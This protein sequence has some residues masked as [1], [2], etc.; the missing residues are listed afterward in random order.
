MYADD[1]FISWTID[2]YHECWILKSKRCF[3]C[4]ELTA[5]T[6]RS[7]LRRLAHCIALGVLPISLKRWLP[8]AITRAVAVTSC[9]EQFVTCSRY[10]L[11]FAIPLGILYFAY[12]SGIAILPQ[13]WR[14]VW[15][16]NGYP[17]AENWC[18]SGS[19]SSRCAS[20][21]RLEYGLLL[22]C[23]SRTRLIVAIATLRVLLYWRQLLSQACQPQKAATAW[24]LSSSAVCEKQQAKPLSLPS[25]N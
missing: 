6:D 22:P 15:N 14:I 2:L 11:R 18:A 21:A 7:I 9:S 17:R 25:P 19:R 13:Y 12:S 1:G 3:Y 10:L 20:L 5:R 16:F 8:F 4:D 23:H 24:R